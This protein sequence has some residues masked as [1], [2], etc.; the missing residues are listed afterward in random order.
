MG[1]GGSHTLEKLVNQVAREVQDP[2]VGESVS[3]RL[4]A[5]IKLTG[6]KE[7]KKEVDKRRN[8][9]LSPLGSGSDY[10]P[11]L[12]HLGIASLNLGYG[13]ENR[14]GSYHSIYDSFDHYTRFGDPQFDYGVTLARTTGRIVLRLAN[15]DFLPFEFEGLADNVDM[16]VEEVVKLVD[17][18]RDDTEK[19]NQMIEEGTYR[20]ALDP[21]KSLGAP[22]KEEPVPYI[23]FADLHNAMQ[24]L[25]TSVASYQKTLSN[26]DKQVFDRAE[27]GK[28]SRLIY[29]SE[30]KLTREEGL[31]RR[32]WYK[33]HIYA[34]GFYTG[35]GVKT[36]PGIREA[37][38]ERKWDE[39]K[40]QI[41]V[42]AG[43][44]EEFARHLDSA[45]QLMLQN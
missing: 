32:S 16:Y 40:N 27:L 19:L 3:K 39:A 13:G 17:K 29:Q 5:R 4:K 21:S 31:P 9:R 1:A 41:G 14:G 2:Q 28:L 44:I 18:M 35:Y 38:E 30:R 23:A 43:V 24:T 25:K 7:Q 10:T 6:T 37:I 8:F 26:L 45:T 34:P 22:K 42:T 33:H 20:L 11:F 12:Q 36:L 15:A